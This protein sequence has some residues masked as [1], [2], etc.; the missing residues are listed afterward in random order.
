MRPY[1]MLFGRACRSFAQ[2]KCMSFAAA[3]SYFALFSIFPLLLFVISF[4]GFFVHSATQRESTVNALVVLIGH[5]IGRTTI[6]A[7]VDAFAGGRGG[8]GVFGLVVS[9]WSASAVFGAIRTGLNAAW[10]VTRPGPIVPTKLRDLASVFVIGCLVLVS[11]A[12][13]G[14][15]TAIEGSGPHLLHQPLG[16][17]THLM[18]TLLALLAPPAFSF[19]AFALIYYLIPQAKIH[20]RDIWL[21]ALVAA[22]LFQVAQLAFGFYVSNFAHYDRLYGS[23]G[24]VIALLFFM[25]LSANILLLG[26][27]ITRA[28]ADARA[29]VGDRDQLQLPGLQPGVSGKVFGL[30]KGLFVSR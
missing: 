27:E 25:Y 2:D 17:I 1:L 5:G 9:I 30:L 10:D 8:I 28:Y 16:H 6:A 11:L 7:Q 23:L 18:S 12:L 22:V 20:L 24:A 3:I 26:G 19:V 13:T 29:N 21:G 15:L 14:F 4:L